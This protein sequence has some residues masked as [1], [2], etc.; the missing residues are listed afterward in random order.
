MQNIPAAKNENLKALAVGFGLIL[1]IALITFF[2]SG[3]VQKNSTKNDSSITIDLK[4]RESINTEKINKITPKELAQKITTEK[5]LTIIDLRNDADYKKEHIPHSQNIPL[6]TLSVMDNLDKNGNYVILDDICEIPTINSVAIYLATRNFRNIYYLDGGFTA[7]KNNFNP[8]IN[9]G[10]PKSFSDQAKVTY[11]SSDELKKTINQET[12]L[13]IDLR[14]NYEFNLEHLNGAINIPLGELEK[15]SSEIYSS[16][17]K[18]ILYDNTGIDAFKGAVK[19]F[20]LGIPKVL[21][22]SDG[23]LTWKQKGFEIIK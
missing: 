22:L 9:D 17:K 16:P 5:N 14:E 21:T 23:L 18:I 15:R 7:W 2:K 8:T 12:M 6:P 11:I 19:L 3:I 13:I 20:D 10:D 4:K 1:I